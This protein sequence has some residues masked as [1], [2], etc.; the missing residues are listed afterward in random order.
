MNAGLIGEDGLVS[1]VKGL[2][3]C[4]PKCTSL[5]PGGYSS[6]GIQADFH[7]LCSGDSHEMTA[8]RVAEAPS[9]ALMV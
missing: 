9:Y 5:V 6:S 4:P 3:G 7:T 2:V 1:I 8:L